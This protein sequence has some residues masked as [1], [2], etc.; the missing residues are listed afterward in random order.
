MTS[1]SRVGNIHYTYPYFEDLVEP[2]GA[3]TIDKRSHACWY[4]TMCVMRSRQIMGKGPESQIIQ[5]KVGDEI[6]L[7]M[8]VKDTEIARGVALLYGLESPEEFLAYRK[9]CWAQARLLG[10]DVPPEIYDVDPGTSKRLNS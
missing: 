2:N 7:W 9:E 8:E 3:L 1:D 4:Y 6:P 5:Y 10:A